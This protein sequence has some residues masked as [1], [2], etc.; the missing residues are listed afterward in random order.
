MLLNFF[1]LGVVTP[2]LK[3]SILPLKEMHTLC[4]VNAAE[5]PSLQR[6]DI[7]IKD[8][9]ILGNLQAIFALSGSYGILRVLE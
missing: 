4:L 5:P 3:R 6:Y 9:L 1:H 7:D 8:F 2:C